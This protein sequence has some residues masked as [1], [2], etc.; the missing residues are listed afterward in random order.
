[1]APKT[2]SKLPRLLREPT[3][4]F[5]VIAA[6]VLLGQRLAQG[7]SHTIELTPALKADILRRFQDQLSRPPTPAE[8]EAFLSSW[9]AEEALYRE[10]LREGIDRDDVAVRNVLVGK[11]RERLLL[12]TR[13]P[14]PTE[15]DL[16]EYLERHRDQFEAPLIY[17]HEWVAF[18]KQSPMGER[19]RAKAKQQ[20][21]AGATPAAL[22]LRSTAANVD[23]ARIEQE[24]G[25]GAAEQI[26]RLPPGQWQELETRDRWLLVKLIRVHGGLPSAEQ[27]HARLVAGWKGEVAQKALAEATRRVAERYRVEETSR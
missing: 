14:E 19:E 12:E 7:D 18:P 5:F 20:L 25:P 3:L 15:A 2:T 13:L 11:M 6:L 24:L 22:G 21:S 26:A 16:K 4:H 27:L 23:R 9:K 8:V 10:A 1:M 17:E